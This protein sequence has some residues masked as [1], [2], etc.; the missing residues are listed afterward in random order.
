MSD[1][2]ITFGLAHTAGSLAKALAVLLVEKKILSAK[3]I[4][5]LFEDTVPLNGSEKIG[6]VEELLARDE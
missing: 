4:A 5:D 6:G 2:E 1:D 3:E